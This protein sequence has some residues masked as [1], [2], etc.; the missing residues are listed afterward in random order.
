MS[1]VQRLDQ[2]GVGR[3]AAARPPRPPAASRR[4]KPLT[5]RGI[6]CLRRAGHSACARPR[7]RPAP[8][9]SR[10]PSR[11]RRRSGSRSCAMSSFS[12]S[13]AAC[14]GAAPPNAIMARP[15]SSLPRSTAWTR[16]ALAMF[17]S[18][19]S[20]TPSARA[21]RVEIERCADMRCRSPL[22]R[23]SASSLHAAAGEAVGADA[24]EHD[25]G[26]GDGRLGAAA[27]VAGGPGLRAG[28][29][30]ADLDA[31]ERI[32]CRDRAAAGADLDHL[33]HRDADRQAAA[34][35][36][37]ILPRHFEG[38]RILR[39]ADRRSGRSSRSCRPCRTRR[40]RRKPHCR[41]DVAREDRAAGR[42]GLD[43]ADRESAAPSRASSARRA[44]VI[45]N[46]AGR[47]SRA[48]AS[49]PR[50]APR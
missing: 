48:R 10:P 2:L 1:A 21:R 32:D 37:A 34:L 30:R 11:R 43:Q 38:A 26:V 28:A 39:L 41:G 40:C 35:Q 22:R 44:E 27:A 15:D 25:I 33:D 8:A 12:A 13:R 4:A 31:R 6:E 23:R 50:A 9:E 24:A 29:F 14:S 36:E 49:R 46:K 47:R 19:I 17:S 3:R 5:R 45:M 7:R 16:A 42:A 20:L 18:T